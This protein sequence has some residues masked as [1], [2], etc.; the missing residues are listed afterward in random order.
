MSRW[1]RVAVMALFVRCAAACT[2]IGAS[3][4]AKVP[5]PVARAACAGV[6][7]DAVRCRDD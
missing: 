7:A 4:S 5:E 6:D 3:T 2:E 1:S